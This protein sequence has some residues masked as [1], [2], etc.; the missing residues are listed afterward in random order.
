MPMQMPP[1]FSTLR[2]AFVMTL[3]LG[4]L[5]ALTGRVAYLQTYGREQTIR[6]AERQ[7]HINEVLRAR[8]GCIFDATGMLVAGTVQ[9]KALFVDP[10]FMQQC[11]EADGRS[12]VDMDEAI[13]KLAALIDRDAFELSTLLGD[14][15]E[16]RYVK[17]A[18][19]LDD[20]TAAAIRQLDLPGVGLTPMNVRFYPMG[21]IAA[22]VLGGTGKEGTGLEGV[23]LR[24]E[25]ELAGRDGFKR[26]L[27][28][29]R[30]RPIAVAA[31][32][33]LSPAHGQHLVLTIDANIQM[34]AEQEL[35]AQCEAF[36][37]GRGEAI[38]MDPKTGDV[39]AMANWPTFNPQNMEDSTP[40][41]RRNRCL[42]DPYEPGST[43]KPFIVGPA[44]AQRVT[45]PGEVWPIAGR[46]YK[47]PLRSKLVTDVHGYGPLSTWDVLV[48]S[49]NVGMTMLAE[50]LGKVRTHAALETWGFGKPTGIELPGE[51]P[52]YLKPPKRWADSDLVSAVQGYSIM[53][54][55]IQLARAFSAYANGGRLVQPR[56]VRG[57]LDA[58]GSVVSR[59][60]ATNLN[61]LPEVLDP[62]TAAAMKRIMSDT[63]VRGTATKARSQAWNLF[64][65]TGTAHVAKGGSYNETS[66]TSSFVAG[67]PAESPRLV[68]AFIIHEPDR[69]HAVKQGLSY[70]GGAV[71]A[72]GAGRLME[73]ALAYLQV[74]ASPDLPPPPPQIASVLVNYNPKVYQRQQPKK[75]DVAKQPTASAAD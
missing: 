25:K 40:D 3:I 44:I 72:P 69:D 10:K 71:A 39:L 62:M 5:V 64:G 58:D 31:E 46:S 75:P 59:T 53:V 8:R 61:M 73:R 18:E 60:E 35:A 74:P 29:A 15:Y 67:A 22:H 52:G 33:Y 24:F 14:R 51:D 38:V 17:I 16:S 56:I 36:R 45:R 27:K 65:K 43:F 42:T 57:V 6:R 47:S 30:R 23:E 19:N 66:Y 41:V 13:A 54:T 26:T 50:R 28:D 49:S 20:G 32:D 12:L 37:A 2:A 34:I 9:Q 48:K 7:Q 68:I 4:G 11:F 55:P 70:Y 21:S 1:A 63:V